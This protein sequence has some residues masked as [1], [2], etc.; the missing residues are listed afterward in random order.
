MPIA[1]TGSPLQ[2]K[3]PSTRR[4]LSGRRLRWHQWLPLWGAERRRERFQ[5]L[6]LLLHVLWSPPA[7]R[8]L[9]RPCATAPHEEGL[10]THP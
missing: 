7:A 2:Q 10:C 4:S 5:R 8:C 6:V 3:A 9:S 1:T